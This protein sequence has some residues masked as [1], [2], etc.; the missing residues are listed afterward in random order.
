[1]QSREK[2]IF[3]SEEYREVAGEGFHSRS[4]S[5]AKLRRMKRLQG[6]TPRRKRGGARETDAVS[7]CEQRSSEKSDIGKS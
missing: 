4:R 1:M 7:F 3:L 2:M 6:R 5:S